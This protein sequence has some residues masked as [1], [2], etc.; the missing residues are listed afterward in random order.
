[1]AKKGF[2]LNTGNILKVFRDV[3]KKLDKVEGLA[4]S[5]MIGTPYGI[6]RF[7]ADKIRGSKRAIH[8]FKKQFGTIYKVNGRRI[9]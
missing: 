6:I 9:K 7:G 5:G 8:W 3:E 1:M 2:V 4:R